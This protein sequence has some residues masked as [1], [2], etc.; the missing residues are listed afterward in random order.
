MDQVSSEEPALV[1]IFTVPRRLR[2]PL[3]RRV[4]GI[5]LALAAEILLLLALLSLNQAA[6]PIKESH[7]TEVDL[8]ASDY[9]EAAEEQP[10]PDKSEPQ[11]E[12]PATPQPV[13]TAAP[14][15]LTPAPPPAAVIPLPTAP[16][17]PAA[18]P[19]PA[20]PAADAGPPY[21]PPDTGRP[22]ATDSERVGT[23]P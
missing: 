19:R 2:T 9:A 13:E 6:E 18:A 10:Q 5:A 3:R 17:A 15:P 4:A 22:Q 11:P 16:T 23:A 7:L 1:R 21:G 12:S 14:V 20:P 8:A